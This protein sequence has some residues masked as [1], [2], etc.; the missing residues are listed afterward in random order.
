MRNEYEEKLSELAYLCNRKDLFINELRKK[1]AAAEEDME[2]EKIFRKTKIMI[3]TLEVM[4]LHDQ[5]MEVKSNIQNLGKSIA[6]TESHNE[7]LTKK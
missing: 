4:T 3:P 7:K 1:L 6:N 2:N 5:L